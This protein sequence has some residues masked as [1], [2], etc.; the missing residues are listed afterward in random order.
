MTLQKVLLSCFVFVILGVGSSSVA[1]AD[2]LLF[3]N[4]VALQGEGATRVDLFGNPGV[5]LTGP[6]ISFVVDITGTVPDSPNQVLQIRYSEFGS[7][8]QVFT[9]GIPFGDIQPPFSM[10][11]TIHSPGANYQGVMATLTL[12]LLGSDPDFVIPGGDRSGERVNSYTYSLQVAQ[13]V[14]E[15]ASLV[16]ITLGLAG[17]AGK[18]NLLRRKRSKPT[19]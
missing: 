3:S 16:M 2:P 4:V 14:P 15:P 12:D 17:L 6:R 1:Q 5:M 10:L 19:D 13:P 18:V 8:P 9:F 7:A 11:F